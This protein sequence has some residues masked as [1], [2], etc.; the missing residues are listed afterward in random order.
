MNS[1]SLD[2]AEQSADTASKPRLEDIVLQIGE[3]VLA[4]T[5][6]VD[7]LA[8]RIEELATQVQQQGYQ[9]FALSDEVQ[10]LTLHHQE[11]IDRLT[12]LSETLTQ[13]AGSLKSE[14]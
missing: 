4:T 5:H 10:T 6:T 7:C 3:A 13:V 14:A 8:A 12:Q 11:T 1:A 2:L 9:I